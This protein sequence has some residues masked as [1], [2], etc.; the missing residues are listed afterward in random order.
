MTPLR[1]WLLVAVGVVLVVTVPLAVR[2]V[3]PPGSDI[4]AGELLALVLDSSDQPYSGYV[5]SRGTL[6]V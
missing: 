6:E 1:R 5:D 4:S 3:P 2:A